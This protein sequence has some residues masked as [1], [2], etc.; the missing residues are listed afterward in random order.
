M[1][2]YLKRYNKRF[3][4]SHE[5]KKKRQEILERD[6]F[7][8]QECKKKGLVTTSSDCKTILSVHHKK[9]YK[10]YPILGL[11][12]KNLITLCD[13][14]H[15]KYHPEKLKSKEKIEKK[16]HKEIWD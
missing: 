12:D 9:H 6:N 14:C 8:C 15:N 13:R 10:K 16:I 7:E 5:W 2:Q 1:N 11:T 4:K 3:Y